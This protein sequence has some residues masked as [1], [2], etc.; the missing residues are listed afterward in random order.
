MKYETGSGLNRF[1]YDM[2]IWGPEV[3]FLFHF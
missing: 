3:G 2:I 1:V